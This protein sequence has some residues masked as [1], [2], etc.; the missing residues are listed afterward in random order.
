MSL[1]PITGLYNFTDKYYLIFFMKTLYFNCHYILGNYYTS[2]TGSYIVPVTK[3][4]ITLKNSP[5][6]YVDLFR[7]ERCYINA[8]SIKVQKE[9]LFT[10][11][12]K[13]TVSLFV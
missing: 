13:T 11:Y 4:S 9:I 6:N 10:S 1:Y 12:I 8:D 7:I 5:D 3:N 2:L